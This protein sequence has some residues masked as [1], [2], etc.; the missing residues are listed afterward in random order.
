MFIKSIDVFDEGRIVF[1]DDK[2]SPDRLINEEGDFIKTFQIQYQCYGVA[3]IDKET[4][5]TA[6]ITRK[7]FIIVDVK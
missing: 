2:H 5:A 1:V 4:V 3:V 7:E 6:L